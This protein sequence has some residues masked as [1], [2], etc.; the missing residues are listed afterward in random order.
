VILFVIIN[1][2]LVASVC[3][4][5]LCSEKEV[6]VFNCELKKSVSSL[7]KSEEDG[8]LVYRNGMNGVVNL[9]V[10]DSAGRKVFYFSNALYAGG[11]EA[12]IRFYRSGYTYYLYDK[13]IKE[14]DGPV[15]SSGI[16][17]YRQGRKISNFVCD[18]DASIRADA[19][20]KII[21]EGYRDIGAK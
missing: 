17:V 1:A 5:G 11:G 2:A 6:V 16:V 8:A 14:D 15:F 3:A 7:C 12:H 9:K 10:S 13:V 20:K 19:Y 18:N 4:G 21:R